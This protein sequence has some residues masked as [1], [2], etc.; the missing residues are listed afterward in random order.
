MNA[1]ELTALD[2][3]IAASDAMKAAADAADLPYSTYDA[4]TG[5]R[6]AAELLFQAGFSI[7]DAGSETDPGAVE[8]CQWALLAMLD[9][10]VS[11]PGANLEIIKRWAATVERKEADK[12]KPEVAN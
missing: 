9:V 8:Q 7:V 6:G 2:H 5:L 3:L 10:L 4:A 11:Q 12:A 1:K